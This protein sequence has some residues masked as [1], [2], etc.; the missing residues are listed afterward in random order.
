MRGEV[1]RQAHQGLTDKPSPR[2]GSRKQLPRS[3]GAVDDLGRPAPVQFNLCS[4]HVAGT[5]LVRP[6]HPPLLAA[7]CLP[8]SL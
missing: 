3:K 4:L 2:G 5:R 6:I 7:A 8:Q 1:K